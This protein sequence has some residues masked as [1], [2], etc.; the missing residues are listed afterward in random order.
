MVNPFPQC[1][2]KETWAGGELGEIHGARF[3]EPGG[4]TLETQLAT[5]A[6]WESRFISLSRH[7]LSCKNNAFR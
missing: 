3:P 5:Y 4:P 6:A 7:C 1:A 2:D